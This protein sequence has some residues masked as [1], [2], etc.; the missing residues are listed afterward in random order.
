MWQ[1]LNH[2]RGVSRRDVESSILPDQFN[3][4]FIN[5]ALD[6]QNRIGPSTTDPTKNLPLFNHT[7]FS[8]AEVTFVEIRDV[9]DLLKNKESKDRYGF[10][11]DLIKCLKKLIISPLTKL[12]NHCIRQ[13]IFP[14]VLKNAVVSPI[15]KKGIPMTSPTSDLYPCCLFSQKSLGNVWQQGS[16]ISL[17]LITYS[18]SINLALE[19]VSVPLMPFW[20]WYQSYA[21]FLR[22]VNTCQ[23]CC[24]A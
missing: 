6:L 21:K 20:I 19:R 5:A 24:V 18:T 23:V 16:L 9:I 13:N 1:I 2:Y 17:N 4:F 15:F 12:I 14:G 11:V 3:H 7:S 8:I 10:T 22:V